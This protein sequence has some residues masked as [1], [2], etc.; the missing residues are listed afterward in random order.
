MGCF[1]WCF[2]ILGYLYGI[3]GFFEGL[4]TLFQNP[5][6]GLLTWVVVAALFYS[7]TFL[8][9]TIQDSKPSELSGRTW[10]LTSIALLGFLVM[11]G[12]VASS[13]PTR[14]GSETAMTLSK[15]IVIIALIATIA[16]VGAIIGAAISVSH[17]G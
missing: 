9:Y 15:E 11:G 2:I 7:C 10:I 14:S 17:D 13:I 3:F 1:G 5:V 4:F 6:A 16:H 8:G 12:V